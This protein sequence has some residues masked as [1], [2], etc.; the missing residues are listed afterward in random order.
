MQTDMKSSAFQQFAEAAK[1]IVNPEVKKWK[2]GGGKVVGYFCTAMPTEMVT[3]ADFLPFRVRATG[4][5][6]T[7]LSDSYFSSINCSFPRHAFNMAL[8]GEYDFIDALVMFN[9]CDHIRRVYDHWIRQIGTPFVKILS[10][11]RKC[12]PPQVEWF[13]DELSTLRE[14]MQE[15]FGVE[16]TDDRLREAIA[17]HNKSRRMLRAMYE[18]RKGDS[19]PITGAEML[20]V[21]VAGTTMPQER[22]NQLLGE[23]SDDI[24]ERSGQSG[25]RARLMII[26]GELDNPEYIEVI[27]GQGGLVVTDAVC[28]GSRMIWKDVEEDADDPLRALAQYYIVDR[29]A[30]ARMYSEYPRRLDFIKSLIKDFNVDAVIFQRLTFCELWGFEQ[31]SLTNDFKEL[32]V[33]L[34]CLDREY[35]M[36]GVGQLRTRVQAFLETMGR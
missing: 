15:H 7:E 1:T 4:S 20:A 11:P 14:A 31:Y 29:P 30:C 34:M 5:T 12:E 2:E 25:F 19:P 27:E 21:T 18:L 33:P 28:F 22:Y 9:S 24:R 10:L 6:E 26:G 32:D 17:L 35:T 8:K 3:A 23:L 36:S 13:R 16:I